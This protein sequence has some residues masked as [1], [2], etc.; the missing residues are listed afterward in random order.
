[1]VKREILSLGRYET[2]LEW[3]VSLH[4]TL[5]WVNTCAYLLTYFIP[6]HLCYLVSIYYKGKISS[7]SKIYSFPAKSGPN[8][9]VSSSK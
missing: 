6:S 1:M 2:G 7:A 9:N 4:T 5:Y 3:T 8:G